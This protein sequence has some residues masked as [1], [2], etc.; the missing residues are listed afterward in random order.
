M[1]YRACRM[2]RPVLRQNIVPTVRLAWEHPRSAAKTLSLAEGRA[3]AIFRPAAVHGHTGFARRTG[4]GRQS[5]TCEASSVEMGTGGAGL[6]RPADVAMMQATDFGNLH[7]PA[8]VGEL[9]GPGVGRILVERKMS[10]SAVIVLEVAGQDAAEVSFA[11]NE[12]VIQTLA[13]DRADEARGERILPGAV[14]R[15]EDFGDPQ[16]LHAVPKLLA[17]DLVAVAQEIGRCGV[18]RESVHDLLG[19][20]V[21]GGVLGHVE[22]D[23][24]PAMVG[25][26]DEDEEDAEASGGH[27]EEID[28]DQVPDV[29][30]Q[31]RPPGLRG[32]GAPLREQPRDGAFGH[33]DAELQELTMD[34]R[35]APERFA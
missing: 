15:R 35:G 31:K 2:R 19:G 23:D 8:R 13:P 30:G 25:E 16:A 5:W 6:R 3:T 32:R 22:M 21:G 34:S 7:D 26:H 29:I 10:A 17:V 18:V 4:S 24:A 14:G 12:H 9:D 11:E 28:R 1:K 20:P 27:G 33:I